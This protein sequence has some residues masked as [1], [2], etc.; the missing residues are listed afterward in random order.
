MKDIVIEKS[1]VS[2]CPE[3]RKLSP[4][5]S[6]GPPNKIQVVSDPLNNTLCLSEDKQTSQTV[7]KQLTQA[8][9]HTKYAGVMSLKSSDENLGI[10]FLIIL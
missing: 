9:P 10:F 1:K 6:I 4:L 7:H 5:L 2:K 3:K 8:I